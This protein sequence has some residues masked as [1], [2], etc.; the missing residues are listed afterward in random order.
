[1]RIVALALTSFALV[2][3][4]IQ[5]SVAEEEPAGKT[6]SARSGLVERSSKFASKNDGP[7]AAGLIVELAKK[8]ISDK[9]ITAIEMQAEVEVV[10]VTDY[11]EDT[12]VIEFAEA[13]DLGT[14][15]DAVAA[16]EARSDVVSAEPNWIFRHTAL[17]SSDDKKIQSWRGDYKSYSQ[18][19]LWDP[20]NKYGNYSIN[21]PAL[22]KFTTGSPDVTVAVLDTG[23]LKKH[24]DLSGRLLDGYDFVTTTPNEYVDSRDGDDWDADPSDPGDYFYYEDDYGRQKMQASSWHGTSVASLIAANS[25]SKGI[26]GVAPQVKILPVRV[27][28]AGGGTLADLADGIRWAAGGD[29]WDESSKGISDNPNPANVIN[30]SLATDASLFSYWYDGDFKGYQG[31]CLNSEFGLLRQAIDAARAE[32]AVLI[33]ARGNEED[34]EHTAPSSCPGVI[35]VAASTKN[36]E[37]AG[38]SNYSWPESERIPA[39]EPR[40]YYFDLDKSEKRSLSQ[41]PLFSGTN[42][43]APGG[44]A[45]G[46]INKKIATNQIWAASNKGTK[47]P[48]SNNWKA[49][50]G[51]SFA[52]PIVA[53]AAALMFSMD[54]TAEDVEKA[55]GV[56]DKVGPDKNGYYDLAPKYKYPTAVRAGSSNVDPNADCN[57]FCG[58]GILDLSKIVPKQLLAKPTVSGSAVVGSKLTVSGTKW[59][60]TLP[61]TYEWYRGETKIDNA[62][63]SSYTLTLADLNQKISAKVIRPEVTATTG[64][65]QAIAVMSDVTADVVLAAPVVTGTMKTGKTLSWGTSTIK[66]Y[67]PSETN[68]KDAYVYSYQWYRSDDGSNFTPI[69]NATKSTYKLVSIDKSKW[70]QVEVKVFKDQAQ[71]PDPHYLKASQPRKLN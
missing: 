12:Q 66:K 31:G 3:G 63:S 49:N 53:G 23:I 42:L 39:N 52:A 60:G 32:G 1:M 61:L 44:G 45:D 56:N 41:F 62:T 50:M 27:L 55:F 26:V 9:S 8:E 33:A 36:G 30:M 20:A 10:E 17:P 47:G 19:S 25:N 38:Y 15:Q 46:Y 29:A 37:I 58:A 18:P 6:K 59:T 70:I 11:A 43:A 21:A 51:T 57:K 40:G 4:P 67:W 69:E 5:V 35:G 14:V 48:S 64:V 68:K 28:G 13:A 71:N 2:I 16:A 22:W 54:Y 65:V 24:P 7:V 34:W